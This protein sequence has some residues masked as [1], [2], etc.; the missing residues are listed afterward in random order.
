M[1][2]IRTIT[3]PG[4]MST[5]L[6]A[7]LLAKHERGAGHHICFVQAAGS[8]MRFSSFSLLS[9]PPLRYIHSF[10]FG[11]IMSVSYEWAGRIFLDLLPLVT[12]FHE[13]QRI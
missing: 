4:L 8:R 12:T 1:V 3:L 13:M 2:I 6:L 7:M 9:F 10:S 5:S 11:H